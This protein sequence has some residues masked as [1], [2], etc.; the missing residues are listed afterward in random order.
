MF[1]DLGACGDPLKARI[2]PSRGEGHTLWHVDIEF[3]TGVGVR[4]TREAA[5]GLDG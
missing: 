5:E 1:K 4:H 2:S 3:Q